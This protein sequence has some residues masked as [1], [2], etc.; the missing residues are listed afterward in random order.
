MKIKVDYFQK[1]VMQPSFIDYII[2]TENN[3]IWNLSNRAEN[4]QFVTAA[5]KS[6]TVHCTVLLFIAAVD[7]DITYE[8]IF[9]WT[10]FKIKVVESLMFIWLKFIIHSGLPSGMSFTILS[11]V[12]KGQLFYWGH[13]PFNLIRS[14]TCDNNCLL[15]VKW[16]AYYGFYWHLF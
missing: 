16:F 15:I 6:R 8:Y 9:V 2:F 13:V 11:I 10:F 3:Q 12:L 1:E 7:L 5:I 4:L 14:T